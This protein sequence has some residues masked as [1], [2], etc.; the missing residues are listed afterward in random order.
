MVGACRPSVVL[1]DSSR[2]ML[3]LTET[4][5]EDGFNVVASVMDGT[6]LLQTTREF[7]P[8]L[9]LLDFSP[10]FGDAIAVTRELLNELPDT[11]VVF[12]STHDDAAYATAAFAAG[13]SGFLVKQQ[14]RDLAN[15][16]TRILNGER[17]Q[18]PDTLPSQS[19]PQRL[20]TSTP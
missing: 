2:A 7:R 17:V 1:G 19:K 18:Y 9:A 5:L 4:M 14:T 3:A 6:S 8:A 20:H 15:L 16:L 10:S 11:K 12:F 13:A